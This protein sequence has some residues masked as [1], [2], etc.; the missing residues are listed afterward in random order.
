MSDFTQ[1]LPTA[2]AISV[3][4]G[5]H[6][7]SQLNGQEGQ[8][9]DPKEMAT[10]AQA[11]ELIAAL[12]SPGFTFKEWRPA[13][14]SNQTIIYSG[15]ERILQLEPGDQSVGQIYH[16]W[17]LNPRGSFLVSVDLAHVEWKP[18][19]SAPAPDPGPGSTVNS[20][21]L[22]TVLG[23]VGTNARTLAQLI[24]ETHD[25]IAALCEKDGITFPIVKV[26]AAHPAL[27]IAQGTVSRKI[28]D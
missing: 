5:Q 24:Q 27:R 13:D 21:P 9:I 28:D 18:D 16:A 19:G 14:G 4:P 7:D 15:A 6:P 22:G 20:G 10:P 8:A 25:G 26:D 3:V 11:E 17:K 1:N 23:T 2:V 12:P